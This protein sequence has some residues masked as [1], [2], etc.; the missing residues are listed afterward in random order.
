MNEN[1]RSVE[2]EFSYHENKDGTIDSICLHCYRTVCSCSGTSPDNCA[3]AELRH[4]CNPDDV[5]R[6]SVK[7]TDQNVTDVGSSM[8][9][10][11]LSPG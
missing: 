1:G 8:A 2:P 3:P 6:L 9:S 10:D 5:A 4:K 7:R 11:H